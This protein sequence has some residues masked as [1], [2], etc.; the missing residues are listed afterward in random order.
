[1]WA[2]RWKKEPRVFIP[3]L[4]N[5]KAALLTAWEGVACLPAWKHFN[6]LSFRSLQML[7]KEN[8]QRNK[9]LFNHVGQCFGCKSSCDRSGLRMVLL[10]TVSSTR[11]AHFVWLL[12]PASVYGPLKMLHATTNRSDLRCPACRH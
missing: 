12:R 6:S 4:F 7:E 2:C 1:M 10:V 3:I 5:W 8:H 11:S 9:D